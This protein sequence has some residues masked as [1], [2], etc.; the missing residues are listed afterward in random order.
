M[1]F[2]MVSSIL[3]KFRSPSL[4]P[5]KRKKGEKNSQE[6]QKYKNSSRVNFSSVLGWGGI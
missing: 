6:I 4:P 3:G 2:K 1:H 5:K